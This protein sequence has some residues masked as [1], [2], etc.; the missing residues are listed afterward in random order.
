[1]AF[2]LAPQPNPPPQAWQRE[3]VQ[4]KGRRLNIRRVKN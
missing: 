1:M 2:P 4:E 3:G